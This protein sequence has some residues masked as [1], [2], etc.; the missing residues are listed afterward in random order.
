MQ[1]DV[2]DRTRQYCTVP[3][4]LWLQSLLLRLFPREYMWLRNIKGRGELKSRMRTRYSIINMLFNI[5]GQFLTML[6]SFI[7]R[8]VFHPLPFGGISGRQRSV[9]RC[10]QYP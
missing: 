2:V 4:G 8:M 10:A 7:N 3:A 6:L 1:F 9:Y 5:G